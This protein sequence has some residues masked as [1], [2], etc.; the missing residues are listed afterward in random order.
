MAKS[1]Y[2]DWDRMNKKQKFMAIQKAGLD[3]E[4]AQLSYKDLRNMVSFTSYFITELAT[5]FNANP[6]LCNAVIQ[7]SKDTV[8]SKKTVEVLGND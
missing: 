1:K 8:V 2:P 7:Q 6:L 5:F 3:E 4:I